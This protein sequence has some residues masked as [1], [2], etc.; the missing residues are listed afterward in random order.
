MR[1]AKDLQGL[2]IVDVKGGNKLGSAD[3][4]VVSPDNGRV[5][6]FVMK[7][8]GVLSP[9]ERIVEMSDVRSIGPDAI[10]VEG[11]EVAHT[12]GAAAEV[13][14]Q[15]RSGK[16]TLN[17]KKVVT[18]DG[19]V[20]GTVTDYTIDEREARVTGLI[21]GGGLFEKGDVIPADRIVSVGS[22]V[23]VVSEPGA[24]SG[25]SGARPFIS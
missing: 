7:S 19:T 8:M 12:S 3:E 23:V 17:G 24:E 9:N 15:A 18:Q 20:V 14:Q 10:T 22:D 5:L 11:E 4:I 25:A 6:G 1:N 21:L 2:A 13:F 16:R